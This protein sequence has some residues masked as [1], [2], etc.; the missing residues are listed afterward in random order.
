MVLSNLVSNIIAISAIVLIVGGSLSY[1][2]IAKVRGQKCIGC[3]D[4]KTCTTKNLKKLCCQ[5]IEKLKEE[6]KI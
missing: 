4:S 2:I 5:D 6:N 3:P 1:I